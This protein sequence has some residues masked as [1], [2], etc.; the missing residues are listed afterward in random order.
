MPPEVLQ[1]KVAK[2]HNTVARGTGYYI[3]EPSLPTVYIRWQDK[4]CVKL[5]STAHPGHQQ[6]IEKHRSKDRTGQYVT[7]DVSLP[8]VAKQ[9]NT[10]MGDIDESD[11][12]ISYH[13]MTRQ[14]P[15]EVAIMNAFH[16]VQAISNCRWQ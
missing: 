7:L 8:F 2:T 9:Y 13:R 14:T 6:G 16:H 3:C 12:L 10:F 4:E 5:M 15:F 1:M 11:Q